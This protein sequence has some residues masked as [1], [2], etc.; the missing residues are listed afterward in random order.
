MPDLLSTPAQPHPHQ[1]R[2]APATERRTLAVELDAVLRPVA[3]FYHLAGPLTGR[4]ITEACFRGEC[5]IEGPCPVPV[6]MA[7]HRPRARTDP[8]LIV[9]DDSSTPW[10]MSFVTCYDRRHYTIT[11]FH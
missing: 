3:A 10:V 9:L 5:E 11:G 6:R 2:A 1:P 4:L 8:R 7:L